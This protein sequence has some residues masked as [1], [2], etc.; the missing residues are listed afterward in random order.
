MAFLGISS[1]GSS[2]STLSD[3]VTGHA[4]AFASAV[5]SVKFC[6]LGMV[7][8]NEWV[9]AYLTILDGILTIYD[10]KE[11]AQ[12][13]ANDIVLRFTIMRGHYASEPHL[14]ENI[15]QGGSRSI[16]LYSFYLMKDY[17]WGFPTKQVKIGSVDEKV[18]KRLAHVINENAN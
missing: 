18:A 4:D 6:S 7:T 13:D 2:Y 9:S 3:P 5:I 14:K 12:T 17:G 8:S 16:N 1:G 15:N 10:C 11:T